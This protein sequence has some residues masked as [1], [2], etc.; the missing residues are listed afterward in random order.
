[1]P[2]ARARRALH[3]A[4]R[5][6]LHAQHGDNHDPLHIVLIQG[7]TVLVGSPPV[8]PLHPP[9]ERLTPQQEEILAVVGSNWISAKKIAYRIGRRGSSYIRMLLVD[10]VES[11]HLV[12]EYG[13][14][15]RQP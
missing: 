4:A 11:G 6:L 13:R 10:L 14:G 7:P 3:S 12:H 15:H 5:E 9:R 1:M 8:R 2:R